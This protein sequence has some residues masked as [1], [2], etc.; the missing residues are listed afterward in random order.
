M[1]RHVS[2]PEVLLFTIDA[3]GGHRAAAR[4]LVAAAEETGAA[5]R[6]RV[7]S[8]Q[9]TLLPL[10]VLR[11]VTGASM[12]DAYNLILR[13]H[14]NAFMVPLLRVMHAGI[15]VRRRA[16]VRTLA[17]WLRAQ[18]RPA[19]VVSVFPN[20]NGI[21]KDAL[22]AAHPGVP[23][24]VVLTDLAD[25]PP[26]F[27]IEP[28]I[29]RVVVATDEAR[30]QALAIGI[31]DERIARVSGMVLHPRF[32]RGGGEN[33]GPRFRAEAGFAPDDFVTTLLFGGKGSPEM[34]PL[35][36]RLLAADAT[37]RLVAI[38][39]DN[40]RLHGRLLELAGKAGGRLAALGFTDRV[41]DV[42]EATDVLVTKPGPGS[43]SEAF[44]HGVPVVVTRN[45]HT[46]PQERFN[47]DFV[48]DRGL[49]AVVRH[50]REIPEAVRA[51]RSDPARRAAIRA[52]L[53]ALPP[54]RAVY[55]V[56]DVI[57]RE[58]G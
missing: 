24:V 31:P 22:E 16:I 29:D 27:W 38:S 2:Q 8:F 56:I 25:F 10:D 45:V 42:L 48:R 46:I 20:F 17:A 4:A 6:F 44:Q 19:A 33:A 26:R 49:G 43:L 13:Q 50:W 41:A 55:E 7:E 30:R 12:E 21:V 3:G 51:L 35:A 39:G 57:A 15:R 1:P 23:L 14:W 47:T 9:E 52:R 11:R 53:A 34:L 37:P 5:F 58:T 32:H 36:E 18:P 28:G 40:P 54:N